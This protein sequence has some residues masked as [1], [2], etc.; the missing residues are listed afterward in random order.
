MLELE[1]E[2]LATLL[3]DEKLRVLPTALSD[4][5]ESATDMDVLC[6]PD[7]ELDEILSE[8]SR[9]CGDLGDRLQVHAAELAI[10]ANE[11][12]HTGQDTGNRFAVLARTSDAACRVVAKEGGD[13]RILANLR[14]MQSFALSLLGKFVGDKALSNRLLDR[15]VSAVVKVVLDFPEAEQTGLRARGQYHLAYAYGAQADLAES[16]DNARRLLDYSVELF[17]CATRVLTFETAPKERSLMQSHIAETLMVLAPYIEKS[18]ARDVLSRA[19]E[20]NEAALK[21]LDRK[22][23]LF[24]W[25]RTQMTLGQL[26]LKRAEL[27]G[28]SK[29]RGLYVSAGYVFKA[30]LRCLTKENDSLS[31]A[32]AHAYLAEALMARAEMESE[33][34]KALRSV[35]SAVD[36]YEQAM[37]VFDREQY[38]EVFAVMS[39]TAA[40]IFL[41][42]SSIAGD[43]KARKF[44]GLSVEIYE[45]AISAASS[46]SDPEL[47]ASLQYNLSKAFA[48]LAE[49]CDEDARARSYLRRSVEAG[50]EALKI[51]DILDDFSETMKIH[52]LL[53]L[54]CSRLASRSDDYGEVMD[55]YDKAAQVFEDALERCKRASEEERNEMEEPLTRFLKNVRL[56]KEVDQRIL[57]RK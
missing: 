14:C 3:A 28:G 8:A 31:W 42:L 49:S 5:L 25:V 41:E 19:A 17:E 50:E 9:E 32:H 35:E 26:M 54:N 39:A 6:G 20:A 16:G 43:R 45:K 7:A 29:R 21:I 36:S 37:Q 12:R 53:G 57:D 27:E 52:L 55:F 11:A 48:Q 47:L 15:A 2:G 22:T 38:P 51:A 33:S 4:A 13:A 46:E 24:D 56:Q 34:K 40:D 10:R 44:L 30:V 1:Y 18:E 23:H